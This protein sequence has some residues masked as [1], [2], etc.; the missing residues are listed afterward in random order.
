MSE[1]PELNAGLCARLENHGICVR[2]DARAPQL[3]ALDN[4]VRIARYGSSR[5]PVRQFVV[6]RGAAVHVHRLQQQGLEED[7]WPEQ[8]AHVEL[9]EVFGPAGTLQEES[10]PLQ[11]AVLWPPP[12]LRVEIEELDLSSDKLLKRCRIRFLRDRDALS[13]PERAQLDPEV[14]LHL[15]L[16][17]KVGVTNLRDIRNCVVREA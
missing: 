3:E 14:A 1:H 6:H 17:E 9:A 7:L 8:P 11:V 15:Q 10:H 16:P 12:V 13:R 2:V 4:H 5:V